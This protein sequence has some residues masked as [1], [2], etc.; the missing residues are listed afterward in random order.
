MIPEI[1]TRI[2]RNGVNANPDYVGHMATIIGVGSAQIQVEWDVDPVDGDGLTTN[3]PLSF[4]KE[5]FD[6]VECPVIN[7]WEGD[8]ELL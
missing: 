1:G 4:W 2:R 7:E 5:W 8:L 3:Y 6:V